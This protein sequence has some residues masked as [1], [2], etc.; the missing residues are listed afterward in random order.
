MLQILF[1]LMSLIYVL[2]YQLITWVK[3]YFHYLNIIFSPVLLN[4]SWVFSLSLWWLN[5]C[6]K[7]NKTKFWM[8][9]FP[10][11]Q[12]TLKYAWRVSYLIE[13]ISIVSW[14]F[15]FV[16]LV[17]NQGHI[18]IPSHLASIF[19]IYWIYWMLLLHITKMWKHQ[20]EKHQ[21]MLSSLKWN[22]IYYK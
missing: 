4:L 10:N 5:Q 22:L 8:E 11:F 9:L 14:I 1:L 18:F 7:R 6:S 12:G 15:H 2:S 3:N 17:H 20:Q 21:K 19:A 13:S 16:S